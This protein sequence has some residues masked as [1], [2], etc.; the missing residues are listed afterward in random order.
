MRGMSLNNRIRDFYWLNVD[1]WNMIEAL[2][3]EI[4]HQNELNRVN[5]LAALSRRMKTWLEQL[6]DIYSLLCEA[7]FGYDINSLIEIL[8]NAEYAQ[9]AEDW[10]LLADIYKIQMLSVVKELQE[11]I[12]SMDIM[13]MND[14]WFENNME[15]LKNSNQVLFAK[16][17]SFNRKIENGEDVKSEY[18][19]ELE[20]S[21]CGSYTMAL[22]DEEQ[23]WYLYS[24]HN[25]REG[26]YAFADRYFQIDKTNYLIYGFGLGYH[27]RAF[28]EKNMDMDL[29][30]VEPDLTLLWYALHIA[31]WSD[32][33][34]Q[35]TIVQDEQW[36]VEGRIIDNYTW[37]V[38]RPELRCIRNLKIRKLVEALAHR[39]DV[40][41]T[42]G[43]IFYL[44]TMGNIARCTGYVDEI[45]DELS[46]KRVVIVAAGPSLDI[47]VELLKDKPED[48]KILAVGTT[49]R[50]L[51]NR[52]IIPDY[53]V[54]ADVKVYYQ[55]RDVEASAPVML[56]ATADRRI[57][58]NY[59]GATYLVCQ[60]GYDTA[61]SYAKAHGYRCYESG[62][63][64]ATL[65]LDIA[66]RAQAKAI[67]FIGL[68]LAYYDNRAHAT[69]TGKEYYGGFEHQ[70]VEGIHGE[71][72]NT[73]K[74]FN[75]YREWMERRI[76]R[77][78][79]VMDIIDATENGA[80][81]KG[82]RIMKLQEYLNME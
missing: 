78:D 9:N 75:D 65:A 16:L 69:G 54:V 19:Y 12:Q 70:K 21:S 17:E 11:T 63:S 61:A 49:Y 50:L 44:N 35:I 37:I 27:V 29:I 31:D 74:V 53:V 10:I 42:Y 52:G 60:E 79:V 45:C 68:D 72:L 51:V 80:K 22:Q 64:V 15:V 8:H 57:S 48:V 36:N 58:R 67:A 40:S 1:I 76:E 4:Q 28:L 43:N 14:E 30:V 41:D 55:V 38:F 46:E 5:C 23:R 18:S 82:F 62:G 56:L 33:L 25:P 13:L 7:G 66:I 3:K 81:K 34:C 39:Q 71:F 26:A 47:N 59:K 6:M 2:D 73:S 32:I 24:N 77:P 20:L